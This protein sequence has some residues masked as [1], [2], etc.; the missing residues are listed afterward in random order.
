MRLTPEEKKYLAN[1]VWSDG[2]IKHA[3]FFMGEEELQE[4][5]S[6]HRRGFVTLEPDYEGHNVCLT[7]AGRKWLE[8]HKD[9]CKR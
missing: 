3:S 1:F 6:L 7:D 5:A 2:Q 9:E 4:V 8:K